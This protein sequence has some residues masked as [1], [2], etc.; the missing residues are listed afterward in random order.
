MRPSLLNLDLK[1]LLAL[2]RSFL[3]GRQRRAPGGPGHRRGRSPGALWRAF[4]SLSHCR[5]GQDK[6]PSGRPLSVKEVLVDC[7]AFCG[8]LRPLKGASLARCKRCLYLPAKPWILPG[9]LCGSSDPCWR[10]LSSSS[11][12]TKISYLNFPSKKEIKAIVIVVY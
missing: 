6:P 8:C 7:E 2:P 3:R 4:W 1:A 5:V 12:V 10:L 9:T 11:P